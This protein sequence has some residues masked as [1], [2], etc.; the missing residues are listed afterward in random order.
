MRLEAATAIVIAMIA[1]FIA[2]FRATLIRRAVITTTATT[3]TATTTTAATTAFS[4]FTAI[5]TLVALS[6]AVS[7][8][9]GRSNNGSSAFSAGRHRSLLRLLM[10]RLLL[11]TRRRFIAMAFSASLL[12]ARLA[13]RAILTIW[14][15]RARLVSVAT[16][17]VRP[18]AALFA[19]RRAIATATTI[20]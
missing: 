9:C 4:S 15:I 16:T 6:I 12:L 1:G 7:G 19:A 14:A 10:A 18:V 13:I 3:T 5:A 20:S 2:A 11:R 8:R 17:F